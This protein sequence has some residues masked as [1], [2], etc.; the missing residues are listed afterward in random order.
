MPAGRALFKEG[1]TD[2]RT[3]WI[4]G[5][6]V[7]VSESERTIAMIRGGTPE[8]RT[9]LYPQIPRAGHRARGRRGRL[10]RRSTASCSTS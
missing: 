1:D 8:A 4:V 10:P 2:K 7:E 6:M 5:G 9:P 3:V